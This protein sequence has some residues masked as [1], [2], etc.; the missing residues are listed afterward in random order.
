VLHLVA[1]AHAVHHEDGEAA[2]TEAE[3]QEYNAGYHCRRHERQGGQT[4]L[5]NAKCREV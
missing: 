1:I 5:D 3:Y 4:G 2:D